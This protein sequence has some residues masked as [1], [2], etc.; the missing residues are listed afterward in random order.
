M[1][2]SLNNINKSFSNLEILR[3][4]SFNFEAGHIYIIKGKNGSGKSTLLNI[5]SGIDS[6]YSGELSIDNQVIT[7]KNIIS[8]SETYI[9]YLTQDSIV[10]DDISCL[11][12][13]LLPYSSK[14]KEKAIFLLKEFELGNCIDENASNLSYG[15]RQRLAFARSLYSIKPIIL[16]DEI[17]SNLDDKSR[18]L[19][20]KKLFELSKNHIVIMVAHD[21]IPELT[22]DNCIFV[23]L[24]D[25]QLIANEHLS[26]REEANNES[27]LLKNNPSFFNELINSIKLNKLSYAVYSIFITLFTCLSFIF[28][29]F[30]NTYGENNK[31]NITFQ[32]YIN[33]APGLYVKRDSD[34]DLNQIDSTSIFSVINNNCLFITNKT[35]PN[36]KIVGVLAIQYGENFSD[37]G[38]NLVKGNYPKNKNEIIVSKNAY[39]S[40][41]SFVKENDD[42]TNDEASN[43]F[44]NLTDLGYSIVGVYEP[45]FMITMN[46]II[47]PH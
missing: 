45:E 29:G 10:F 8:Y 12:N 37:F 22:T 42:L 2:L 3:N 25:G 30:Y 20:I 14:N 4:L 41:V 44:F 27:I 5:L 6:K 11:N 47:Q 38:I 43:Q 24:K 35:D 32:N 36:S 28:G 39:D 23:N 33:S 15:E 17:T 13:I 21:E 7:S 34:I 46:C 16:L 18:N 40:Y 19:I 1:K 31:I 26:N 9:S